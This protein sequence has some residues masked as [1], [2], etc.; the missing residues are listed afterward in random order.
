MEGTDNPELTVTYAGFKNGETANVLDQLPTVTTTATTTSA[1]GTYP[2]TVSGGSATN[3]TLIYVNGTLTITKAPS[4]VTKATAARTLTYTGAAQQIVN[5]GVASGGTMQYSLDGTTFSASIPTATDA[6]TY[7][8]YYKVVGDANHYD[9]E[10]A[11]VVVTIKEP[12][13][14]NGDV[15]GDGNVDVADIATIITVMAQ[16][17]KIVEQVIAA[18]VNGDGVVDV[19]D[20]ATVISIMAANARM[21]LTMTE[22]GE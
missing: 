10:L 22:T 9:T 16:G 17:D 6:S 3:Y 20:I 21:Q 8:V 7:K 1:P 2:I 5:A 11:T 4:A 14:K 19:A 15:N 13:R 18:D 12:E